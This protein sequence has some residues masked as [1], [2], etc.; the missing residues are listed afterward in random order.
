MKSLRRWL[1]VLCTVIVA[2]AAWV[3]DSPYFTLWRLH[4]GLVDKDVAAVE[5]VVV[6]E[7]FAASSAAAL[8]GA[9]SSEVAGGGIGGAVAAAIGELVGRGVGEAVAPEAAQALRTQIAD[10]ALATQLGPLVFHQ[11]LAAVGRVG[12]TIDGAQV[13]VLGTCRGHEA[14]VVLVLQARAGPIFGRP[15]QYVVVGIE[16][17]SARRLASDCTQSPR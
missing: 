5:R 14:S 6:L 2:V 10:G 13:E 9:L 3:Y 1:F 8:G 16:P 11:G 15:R 4:Q 17:A 12:L 7:R